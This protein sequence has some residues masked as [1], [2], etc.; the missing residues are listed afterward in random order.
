MHSNKTKKF[1]TTIIKKLKNFNHIIFM[2]KEIFLYD[3]DND[4]DDDEIVLCK[5]CN[6]M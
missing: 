3:D 2:V 1:V 6:F 5:L 4:D